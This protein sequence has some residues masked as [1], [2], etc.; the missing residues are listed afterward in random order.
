M[1]LPAGPF[2]NRVSLQLI[3]TVVCMWSTFAT[4]AAAA[5]PVPV[6]V[7]VIQTQAAALCAN[8]STCWSLA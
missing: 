4:L 3:A 5:A 1:V 2:S 8:T 7:V 6:Q